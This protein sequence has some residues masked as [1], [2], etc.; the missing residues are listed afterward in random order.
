MKSFKDYLSESNKVEESINESNSANMEKFVELNKGRT[1]KTAINIKGIENKN[2]IL[3]DIYETGYIIAYK[4]SDNYIIHV[5][6]IIFQID[7][8]IKLTKDQF[9]TLKRL[10]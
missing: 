1:G 7:D 5:K 10:K 8:R 9:N 3:I 4:D 2:S 6:D